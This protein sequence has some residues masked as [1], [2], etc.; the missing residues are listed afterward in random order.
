MNSGTVKLDPKL[1]KEVRI[2]AVKNDLRFVH[3]IKEAIKQY[4]EKENKKD[5]K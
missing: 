4:L 5:G 2:F 3:V 1:L